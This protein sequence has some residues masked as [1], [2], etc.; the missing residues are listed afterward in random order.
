MK[1]VCHSFRGTDRNGAFFYNDF[2]GFGIFLYTSCRLLN[3]L[4]VDGFSSPFT[5]HFCGGIDRN[6]NNV[7]L[8]DTTVDSRREKQVFPTGLKHSFQQSRLKNREF[9]RVPGID[10]FLGNINDRHLIIRA[11]TGNDGHGRSPDITRSDTQNIFFEIFGCH[12]KLFGK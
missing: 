8:F 4:Q 2:V 5:K 3:K 10:S 11:F 6:K 1:N 9:V 12:Q 7:C